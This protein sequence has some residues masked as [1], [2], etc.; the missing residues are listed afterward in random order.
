MRPTWAPDPAQAPC[1]PHAQTCRFFASRSILNPLPSGWSP[2]ARPPFLLSR[3]PDGPS[4]PKC[5]VTSPHGTGHRRWLPLPSDTLHTASR[6]ASLPGSPPPPAP[7]PLLSTSQASNPG[8]FPALRPPHLP[9]LL[10]ALEISPLTPVSHA[11]LSLELQTP[12]HCPACPR[13][14]ATTQCNAPNPLP[15]PPGKSPPLPHLLTT[16]SFERP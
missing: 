4:G 6:T 8:L 11:D 13:C 15:S 7:R 10:C 3:S 9:A 2:T 5:K 1:C 12:S 16:L 14:L